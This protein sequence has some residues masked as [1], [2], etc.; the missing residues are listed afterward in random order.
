MWILAFNIITG[1]TS[2][3]KDNELIFFIEEERLSKVKYD[4]T[5][6]LGISKALEL[7][8]KIDSVL[9]T[10]GRGYYTTTKVENDLNHTH[11]IKPFPSLPWTGENPYLCYIRKKG[12]ISV[13]DWYSPT[14]TDS[15]D[16][17]KFDIFFHPVSA[18]TG[19]M[20]SGFDD[21]AM[22]V[23]DSLGSGLQYPKYEDFI[24][25]ELD[26]P[27]DFVTESTWELESIWDITQ[28]GTLRKHYANFGSELFNPSGN[29]ID[30]NDTIS[31]IS[32]N[33][34]IIKAVE[35][36]TKFLNFH[37]RDIVKTMQLS[38]YGKYNSAIKIDDGEF[39]NPKLFNAKFT[40]FS[41]IKEDYNS[42]MFVN[43]NDHSWHDNPKLIDGYKKDLAYA[44]QESTFRRVNNLIEKTLDLTRK[45]KIVMVGQIN[46]NYANNYKILKKFPNIKF[47]HDPLV[48]CGGSVFGAHK[49][50]S[51]KSGFA[52]IF[53]SSEPLKSIYLGP[54]N[55]YSTTKLNG[56]SLKDVTAIEIAQL[57][58]DGNLVA[59]Y[60]GRS[61][62]GANALGNRSILFDPTI[63]DGKDILNKLKIKKWF[64]TCGASCLAESVNDWF[65]MAGLT[66]SP[67]MMYAVDV[68]PTKK[69]LI[70]VVVH[71]DGTCRI[72]TVTIEQNSNFYEVIYEFNKIKNVPIVLNTGFQLENSPLVESI[73]D[74][75]FVMKNLNIKYLWLP[76]LKKLAIKIEQ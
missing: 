16:F 27:N 29:I 69:E 52:N 8:D 22:I 24:S 6:L 66:E 43:P 40:N 45:Q 20:N 5:P 51:N 63:E 54:K 46:L 11:L 32:V 7:T 33:N 3:F 34:G 25:K 9:M 1:S 53:P 68:L 48:H 36:V 62:A 49:L 57:I 56:L 64:E 23:I 70:P 10:G 41:S 42:N 47:Y 12:R 2:L 31:T 21:A 19:F 28:Q 15:I 75:A 44:V 18:V 72:Q 50:H 58:S 26:A 76:D 4:G 39:N 55:N 71:N 65:D 73:E 74:A 37:G 61:E 17:T 60:Q 38:A 30:D 14:W 35:A 67:F 59:L 13:K